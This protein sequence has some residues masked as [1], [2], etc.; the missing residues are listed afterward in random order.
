MEIECPKALKRCFSRRNSRNRRRHRLSSS[1]ENVQSQI[2]NKK[3]NNTN[4]G[5]LRPCLQ[6]PLFRSSSSSRSRHWTRR[7]LPMGS[8]SKQYLFPR[9]ITSMTMLV[10]RPPQRTTRLFRCLGEFLSTH[11]VFK[12][13]TSREMGT[14]SNHLKA[15]A[16]VVFE[17]THPLDSVLSSAASVAPRQDRSFVRALVP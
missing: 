16:T 7:Q 10:T 4:S 12:N 11:T 13:S 2:A 3:R 1:A 6:L 17:V 15:T 9:M 8:G 5:Q 14:F